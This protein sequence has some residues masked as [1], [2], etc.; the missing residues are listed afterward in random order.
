M[1]ELQ[2]INGDPIDVAATLAGKDLIVIG[3]T[4]FLGK[5]WLAMLLDRY[6]GVG[7]LY[8][9][10]RTPPVERLKRQPFAA[11]RLD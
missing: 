5:V 11:K 10:V 9:V 2:I 3:A 4:G 1:G 8:T 7:R 6:P